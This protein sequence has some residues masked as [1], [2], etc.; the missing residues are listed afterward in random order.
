MIQNPRLANAICQYNQ[1]IMDDSDIIAGCAFVPFL[2]AM[3]IYLLI[4]TVNNYRKLRVEAMAELAED[5]PAVAFEPIHRLNYRSP[6]RRTPPVFPRP[7]AKAVSRCLLIAFVYGGLSVL[8]VAVYRH[9]EYR[10][11]REVLTFVDAITGA[12]VA[13]DMGYE[14]FYYAQMGD[15]PNWQFDATP[16]APNV[17]ECHWN[18]PTALTL[19]QAGYSPLYVELRDDLSPKLI[20]LQPIK[21]VSPSASPPSARVMPST[22]QSNRN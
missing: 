22:T 6:P 15:S 19:S 18:Y 7:S 1:R 9:F 3:G 2:I 11:R 12:P 4:D 13:I 10:E 16:L 20:K 17:V 21:D 5:P 14:P 8:F